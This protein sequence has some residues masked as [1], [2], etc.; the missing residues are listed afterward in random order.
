MT[1]SSLQP[2]NIN[3]MSNNQ[4]NFIAKIDAIEQELERFCDSQELANET[5]QQKIENL[6]K[7]VS[8]KV[9]DLIKDASQNNNLADLENYLKEALNIS[10]NQSNEENMR[11]AF[12]EAKT[13]LNK[14][15]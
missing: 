6:A 4:H 3:H 14:S 2:T 8:A 13:I 9:G 5:K 1:L 15:F 10:A 12:A 7:M 11:Y